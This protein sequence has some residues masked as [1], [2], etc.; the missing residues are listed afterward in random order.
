MYDLIVLKNNGNSFSWDEFKEAM[1]ER[2]DKPQL[3]VAMLKEHL[4]K[5]RYDG[6]LRMDGVSEYQGSHPQFTS[7]MRGLSV[8]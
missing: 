7:R 3:R 6:S 4:E 1:R 2:Y 5:M 8:L